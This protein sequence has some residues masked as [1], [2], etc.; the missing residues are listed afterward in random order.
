MTAAPKASLPQW[1]D[2]RQQHAEPYDQRGP[3]R[4]SAE[5]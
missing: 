3:G 4:P 2:Q 5:S 1:R